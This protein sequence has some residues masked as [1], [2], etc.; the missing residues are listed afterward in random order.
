MNPVQ[1]EWRGAV[2]LLEGLP[3][4]WYSWCTTLNVKKH[5]KSKWVMFNYKA[6]SCGFQVRQEEKEL[7]MKEAL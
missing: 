1:E 2:G 3:N 4:Q 5:K 6:M 7:N